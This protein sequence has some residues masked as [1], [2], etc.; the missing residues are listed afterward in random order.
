MSPRFGT[1]LT[2]ISGLG[3]C[4]PEC[5]QYAGSRWPLLGRRPPA[6]RRWL[7]DGPSKS[8]VFSLK[9]ELLDP[10][11]R[12]FMWKR[13]VRG[14]PDS[15]SGSVLQ[16]N[17][18]S[19]GMPPV[20]SAAQPR[21]CPSNGPSRQPHLEEPLCPKRCMT[22]GRDRGMAVD[23][24]C[25]I[26]YNLAHHFGY[27]QLFK[28]LMAPGAVSSCLDRGDANAQTVPLSGLACTR[29]VPL[30]GLT[31][32]SFKRRLHRRRLPDRHQPGSPAWASVPAPGLL[33]MKP[34]QEDRP[35]CAENS[36]PP[37]SCSP[38]CS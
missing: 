31:C 35:P 38:R 19:Q 28:G 6:T 24:Q 23:S 8:L 5:R 1:V 29:A 33:D 32:T 18:A 7:G 21:I 27:L 13:Q 10:H 14:T 11:S 36:T 3:K 34:S 20:L 4:G 15:L 9:D 22:R 2:G 12:A 25:R 30:P 37:Y 26:C 16:E 17:A